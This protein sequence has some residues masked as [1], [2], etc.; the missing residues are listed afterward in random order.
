MNQAM[1]VAVWNVVEIVVVGGEEIFV[2]SAV[3]LA[4][5]VAYSAV[6]ASALVVEDNSSVTAVMSRQRQVGNMKIAY[7]SYSKAC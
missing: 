6:D 5:F 3:R 1:V 4:G 7:P 2:D